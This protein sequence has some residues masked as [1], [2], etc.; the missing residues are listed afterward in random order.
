MNKYFLI[1]ELGHHFGKIGRLIERKTDD[2]LSLLLQFNKIVEVPAF[3][4]THYYP[5]LYSLLVIQHE[6]KKLHTEITLFTLYMNGAFGYKRQQEFDTIG[7]HQKLDRLRKFKQEWELLEE[8]KIQY[9]WLQ[10]IDEVEK[11]RKDI[12]RKSRLQEFH[13]N[14]FPRATSSF[15][16]QLTLFEL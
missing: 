14:T 13:T 1:L 3:K 12:E 11:E 5:T 7:T 4:V 10:E 6:I 2:S 15:S 8:Q 9:K 16:Y